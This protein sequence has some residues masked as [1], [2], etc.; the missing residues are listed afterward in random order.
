MDLASKQ[1]TY[2]Q[3]NKNW[4]W[5]GKRLKDGSRVYT[6]EKGM[7]WAGKRC[8][9][10][11]RSRVR[12]ALKITKL[13]KELVRSELKLA[14]YEIISSSFPMKVSK[15]S[16]ILKVGVHFVSTKSGKLLVEESH[17]T[18]QDADIYVLIFRTVRIVDDSKWKNINAKKQFISDPQR[19][20]I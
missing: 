14:G 1:C 2:C 18:N 17:E 20:S 13:E 5:Q 11:E 8:P 12:T 9:S 7:R 15:E 3:K 4:V 10:C 19:L 6:D 16:S